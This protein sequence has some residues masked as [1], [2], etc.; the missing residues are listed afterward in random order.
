[1][2]LRRMGD[3]ELTAARVGPRERHTDRPRFVAHRVRLVA[4]R[5]A[6]AAPSVPSRVAVLDDEV[7]DHAV[8]GGSNKGP[9]LEERQKGRDRQRRLRRKELHHN[10]A[11]LRLEGHPRTRSAPPRGEEIAPRD[12]A[13]VRER[14]SGGDRGHGPAARGGVRQHFSGE[15]A[16]EI[17]IRAG[18]TRHE[19]RRHGRPIIRARGGDGGERRDRRKARIVEGIGRR[20]QVRVGESVDVIHDRVARE[21]IGGNTARSEE[22]TSELQS[23]QYLVCRLLLEKKKKKKREKKTRITHYTSTTK[24]TI[25]RQTT[26]T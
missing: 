18:H 10:R 16:H 2:G 13:I 20:A 14:A 25:Y 26:S 12:A 9:P 3:E 6:G 21:Q 7:R 23:R 15:P 17:V 1:M 8:P 22:H 19:T 5:E 11:P 24:K 4:Q